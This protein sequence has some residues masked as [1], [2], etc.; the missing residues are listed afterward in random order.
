[1]FCPCG[2]KKPYEACCGKYLSGK[3]DAP[4]PEALMRSRYTAF[5]KGNLGYIEAT[6]KERAL[7]LYNRAAAEQS[8]KNTFWIRLDVLE[9]KEEGKK[10][11]VLFAVTF[12]HEGIEKTY[13]ERSFFKKISGKWM[14]VEGEVSQ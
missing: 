13:K 1:M 14:Y 3:E 5:T 6:M 10:G 7:Q 11:M 8:L 4:T 12:K 2:S 9:K